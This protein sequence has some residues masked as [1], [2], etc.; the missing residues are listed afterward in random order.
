MNVGYIV[1]PNSKGQIVIPKSVRDKIGI[2]KD[3][4]LNLTVRGNGIY[5]TPIKHVI[6]DLN[7]EDYYIKILEKTQ[8]AWGTLDN[9]TFKRRRKIEL[10]AAKARKNQW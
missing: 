5:L 7:E 3:I 10:K 8:G 2:D 6:S 1:E 9:E 4:L